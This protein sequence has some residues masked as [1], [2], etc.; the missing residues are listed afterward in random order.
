TLLFSPLAFAFLCIL[1]LAVRLAGRGSRR[2]TMLMGTA[3]VPSAGVGAAL[4]TAFPNGGVYPFH[5]WD[6]A[7]VLSLSVTTASLA[8]PARGGR[9]IAAIFALWGLCCLAAYVIPSPV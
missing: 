7:A 6:L 2:V 8:W 9:P 3:A 1:L 5:G 4:L